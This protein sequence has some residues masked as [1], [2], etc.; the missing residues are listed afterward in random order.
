[1]SLRVLKQF[2]PFLFYAA[3]ALF[4]G[5]AATVREERSLRG[6]LTLVISGFLSWGLIEYILH[7]FIFHYDAQSTLGRKFVH[8]AHLSHHE[9]PRA[10]DNLFASLPISLPIAT[11]YWLLAW[12]LLGTWHAASYLFIGLI[13]GYFC[14]EW[15]HF[16]AHHR[17]PRVR[18][19]RHLKKYHLMHH[20]RTPHM[21][22]G[23]TSPLFDFIFGTFQPVRNA[24]RRRT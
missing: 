15:L 9:N 23:V 14:Y 21:R 17:S 16:Q 2:T 1:M 22:F 11:V 7:R 10:T 24:P 18:L 5:A 6:I 19:L 20:Y 12:A 8:V 3:V 4:L 13:A